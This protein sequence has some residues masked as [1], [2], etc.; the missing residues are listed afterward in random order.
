MKSMLVCR[1]LSVPITQRGFNKYAQLI[2]I[3]QY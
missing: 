2:T 3:E 1:L